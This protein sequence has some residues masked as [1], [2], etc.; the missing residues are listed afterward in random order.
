MYGCLIWVLG[1]SL[2]VSGFGYIIYLE[3]N[4]KLEPIRVKI[5]EKISDFREDN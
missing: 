2:C 1:L 4:N 3:E 5:K